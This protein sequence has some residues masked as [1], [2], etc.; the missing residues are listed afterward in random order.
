MILCNTL[1]LNS[2]FAVNKSKK[3]KKQRKSK[4]KRKQ[5]PGVLSSSGFQFLLT[6]RVLTS[7]PHLGLLSGNGMRSPWD[8]LILT[9][10]NDLLKNEDRMKG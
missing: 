7:F 6:L 4:G 8:T 1:D 3:G 9:R 2:A 5:F 10:K